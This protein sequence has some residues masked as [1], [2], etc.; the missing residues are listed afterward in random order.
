MSKKPVRRHQLTDSALFKCRSKRR[1]ASLLFTSPGKI[2]ELTGGVDP[3]KEWKKK[4]KSSGERLIEAPREDIKK[5]QRRIADL[6]Q[7]I[8]VPDYLY[9]PVT[10]RSYV[11]NASHHSTSNAFRLLDLEDFFPSCR[12]A[13]VAWFFGRLMECSVDVTAIMCGLTTRNGHLPQGSP[14][15]PILAYFAYLD[16]WEEINSIAAEHECRIS[17]YADDVTISGEVVPEEMIWR[18]KRVLHRFGHRYQRDKD[19]SVI[20][21]PV[22]ITGVIVRDGLLLLPNRQHLRRH[23]L[24]KEIRNSQSEQQ[25]SILRQ[26]LRGR[27]AQANQILLHHDSVDLPKS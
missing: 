14:C 21:R 7:R 4:K 10:G 27:E 22:E 20:G 11:D 25:S 19:C 26:R 13:R 17:V 8:E 12:S 3:Y 9:Y 24:K 6:L 18:I 5:I 2:K 23:Q 1:L 16:M 15:S